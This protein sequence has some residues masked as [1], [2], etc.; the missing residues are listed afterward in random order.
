MKQAVKLFHK[1]INDR[2]R[3]MNNQQIFVIYKNQF[4]GK[5]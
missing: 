3:Q 2:N 1:Q 5:K 4:L